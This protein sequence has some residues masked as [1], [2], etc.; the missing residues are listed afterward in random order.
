MIPKRLHYCWFG[1]HSLPPQAE[2]CMRS[3]IENCP[4]YEIIRWDET[5]SCLDDC[6]Y[7]SQ[8][9]K[10]GKWAFVSDYVRLKALWDC[11][12]IYLDTD[13]ELLQPLDAF[14]KNSAFFGFE[15]RE[16]VATCVIGAEAGHLLISDLLEM[17][18][19]ISFLKA[20]GSYDCTT[21][22]ERITDELR[23]RGLQATN[24]FQTVAN[25]AIYPHDVF[26]PKSLE[27]GKIALTKNSCAIHHFDASWMTASQRRHTRI[28]QIV[29]PEWTQRATKFRD[30]IRRKK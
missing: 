11:G 7:V 21:N 18:S 1:G 28:A 3:W 10:A 17:Y 12:G 16:K 8:A 29:G 5:N 26:S 25:V 20:D 14:L 13:V 27:T 2:K 24:E 19:H 9:F 15:S 6:P 22:V 23:K 4:G 30:L